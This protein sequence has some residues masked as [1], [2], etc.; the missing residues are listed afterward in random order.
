MASSEGSVKYSKADEGYLEKRGLKRYAGIWS[1]WA[2]GVGAVISG[3]FFGWNFGLSV[4]GFGGLLAATIII[5]IM[6]V[7][8]CYSIAEM[9]P[10][11]PH[12]GGAYS[13]AR[14][15]MGPWAGYITGLAENMEYVLT[16]AVIVVGIGGYLGSIFNT[17]LGIELADPW[18]WLISYVV[19]VGINFVGVE[20][21]FRFTVVITFLALGILAVFWLGAIPHFSLEHAL[22]IAPQE[23][24]SL[25]LPMGVGGIAAALP[26]A[27][28][29]YLAIEQLPLAAEEAHDPVRDMPRG[30][31]WGILT[32]IIAS[33]LTLFLNAGIA[34]GAAVVGQSDE[35]L[36]LAFQTIFG[37][38]IGASLL[39]LVA[40]AGLI[41]SFHTII[42][43]YGR[44]IYSLSRAGYFPKW[45]SVTHSTR[46]TPYV[47]LVAGA[48]IGFVVALIIHYGEAVFGSVP[49][50]AVLLN[51]AVFGAVIAYIM[52][53]LAFVKLRAM[54]GIERP[55]VSPL[56]N[57]GAIVAGIIA[58]ITLVFLFINEEYRVGIY[59]CAIWFAAGLAYF[60]V[61]SRHQMILSPE[62]EF[63]M[64]MK[65]KAE[66]EAE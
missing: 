20:M 61:H 48:V 24:G 40:V 62:E 33:F 58:L 49:V 28:W 55:Y 9:S 25:W 57:M 36:F 37:D 17:M 7:G 35:P 19:F 52:Q 4:G 51:M 22:D 23:G 50:G 12:T 29:F 11:L 8:L 14:T 63:A 18:W 2:L 46:K 65:A 47:A 21:T 42:Y 38:G 26:F 66:E 3:D 59:G 39:A 27:I 60:A 13:F 64:N 53:M 5:A 1:L 44:N 30:L 10:A 56:G 6:Y 31:L 54:P 16:P 45:L 43:A 32:L 34:P 41:A 15:A